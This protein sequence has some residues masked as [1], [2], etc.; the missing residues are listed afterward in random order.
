MADSNTELKNVEESDSSDVVLLGRTVEIFPA[1]RLERYDNGPVKAYAANVL[2]S[3][4]SSFY[5]LVCE[6]HLVPRHIHVDAYAS[7][8]NSSIAR[9][10]AHGVVWWPLT[11]NQRYVFI[12]EDIPS[13]PLIERGQT[14]A[15]GMRPDLL[16]NGVVK[17]MIGI[18]QDFRDKEFVHGSIRPSNLSA[19]DAD[20]KISKVVLGDC[21]SVPGSYA[22]PVIYQ[23]IQRSVVD[24]IGRGIGS[25]ADDMYSFGATLAVLLR[26]ADPFKDISDAEIVREKILQGSYA[27]LTGKER[28][29][30]AILELLRGLLHDDPM[31]RWTIDEVSSWMDGVRLSPKQSVKYVK[32][33]RPIEFGGKNYAR[34][35]FLAMEINAHPQETQRI[36]ESNEL[37]QWIERS[38]E[39]EE[40][41]AR[42]HVALKSSREMGTGNGYEDR[43]AANL[44]IALDPSAPLRFRG[45][46]LSCDG[47]GSA[48]CEVISLKKD[49]KVFADLFMQNVPMNWLSAQVSSSLDL[50]AL[51]S[52]FDK[53]KKY[54]KQNKAGYGMERCVYTLANEAPCFGDTFENYYILTPEDLVL[55][56]EDLCQKGL[57]PHYLLDRHAM[58]FLAVRDNKVIEGCLYDFDTG[59]ETK[60]FLAGL[61]VLAEIQRRSKM[62]N[63]PGISKAVE[64]H[65]A[66][67]LAM[68][69]DKE[70]QDLLRSKVRPHM[71]QGNLSKILEVIQDPTL[72]KKD[73]KAFS[74]AMA[75]YAQLEAENDIIK[76]NL[77][78]KDN[79]GR[80]AGN[81]FA[82]FISSVIAGIVILFVAFTFV[83]GR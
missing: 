68:Y 25:R 3:P 81:E 18:L 33:P 66:G 47:V 4:N 83:T 17:P 56:L 27:V 60:K 75:E 82:A 7:F 11:K 63:L 23:T 42:Y 19:I 67:I 41:L 8:M 38:L 65:M 76:G 14:R 59:D 12:Y 39:D 31:Q 45:L 22:Q 15:L 57:A 37:E 52:R 62:Q 50:G 2:D 70:S 43:L 54:V 21:L 34:P 6:R 36:V 46:R 20:G 80:A 35:I 13:R 32:A 44:S 74:A 77:A 10:E 40:M 9:L 55:A 53:C 58:A 69:H 78:N 28:F 49:P 64:K 26:A 71:D 29:T 79:F 24:P 48:L 16:L 51:I 1:R 72:K 61:K 73:F 5:A 30:G